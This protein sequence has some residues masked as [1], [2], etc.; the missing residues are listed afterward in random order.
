MATI[1]GKRLVTVTTTKALAAA[2]DYAAGDVL[3]ENASTGTDWDFDAVGMKNG[4][5][6]YIVRANAICET[7]ALTP[8]LTLFLFNA[9]P[10]CETDDNKANTALLHADL[11]NY[12]G[13]I[14]F[15]AME[16]I[17]TGD[18]ESVATSSTPG[19]LPLAFNCASADDALYGI[20]VTRDA[21][22]G[23]SAGDE[24]TIKLVVEQY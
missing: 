20:L 22:T 4:G 17:G 14:D 19:N 7:T 12:I 5:T 11:A 16:D 8:E 2:G 6:G 13:K 21:I 3:S 24:M 15:P 10:T 23:E 1:E 9:A 18:S